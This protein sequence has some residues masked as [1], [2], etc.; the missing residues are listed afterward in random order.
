MS[1]SEQLENSIIVNDGESVTVD[2]TIIA[3]TGEPAVDIH[4]HHSTDSTAD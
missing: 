3:P 1:N 2:E 4:Q